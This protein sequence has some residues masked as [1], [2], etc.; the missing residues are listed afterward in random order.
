MYQQY[1]FNNLHSFKNVPKSDK[2]TVDYN[3]YACALSIL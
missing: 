3:V 1:N 2:Y